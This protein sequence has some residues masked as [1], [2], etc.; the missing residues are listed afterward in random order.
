M[1]VLF[2]GLIPIVG[3]IWLIVLYCKEGESEKNGYGANPKSVERYFPGRRREKSIAIAFIVGAAV[4]L[5]SLALNWIQYNLPFRFWLIP[6]LTSVLMLLFGIFYHPAG[7]LRKTA[8]RRNIAFALLAIAPL[9]GVIQGTFKLISIGNI[10]VP[11]SISAG[12]FVGLLTNIALLAL[13]VLLLLKSERK[14]IAPVAI[15]TIVLIIVSIVIVLGEAFMHNPGPQFVVLNIM[16][17][18]FILLAVH[19][20]QGK[21]AEE[22][23]SSQISPELVNSKMTV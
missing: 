21:A 11:G 8:N 17:I 20:L 16:F 2:I 1:V 4:L 9:I 7:D 15:S 5:A 13:A 18:P 19:C 22:E 14:N 12:N 6:A 23:E 10:D 3:G